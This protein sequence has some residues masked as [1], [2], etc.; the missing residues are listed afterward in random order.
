MITQP[1]EDDEDEHFVDAPDDDSEEEH[2]VDADSDE[3]I[4]S[5]SSASDENDSDSGSSDNETTAVKPTVAKQPQFSTGRQT[6]IK[7]RYVDVISRV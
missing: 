2:F 5:D 3:D 1:E 7:V 6:T 4:S